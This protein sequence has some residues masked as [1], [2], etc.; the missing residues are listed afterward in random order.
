MSGFCDSTCFF[1]AAMY[2]FGVSG[3]E[4]EIDTSFRVRVR[5]SWL[6]T[7]FVLLSKPSRHST[8]ISVRPPKVIICRIVSRSSFNVRRRNDRGFIDFVPNSRC[9]P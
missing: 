8:E 5:C 3:R 1:I 7:P 6:S 4:L 2:A 9:L